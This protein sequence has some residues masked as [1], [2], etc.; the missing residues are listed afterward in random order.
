MC[1]YAIVLAYQRQGHAGSICGPAVAATV[2]EL[3][4]LAS[5]QGQLCVTK[6]VDNST[7]LSA[8]RVVVSL[9]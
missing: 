1:H 8:R 3:D 9:W 6:Q 7:L 2:V 5:V 4:T